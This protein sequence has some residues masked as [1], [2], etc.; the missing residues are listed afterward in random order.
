MLFKVQSEW[1]DVKLQ[2]ASVVYVECCRE[3][4][5]ERSKQSLI[6]N[7]QQVRPI[8]A[9]WGASTNLQHRHPKLWALNL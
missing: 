3:A 6:M 2:G 1:R 8:P 7:V 5:D 9:Q 4:A